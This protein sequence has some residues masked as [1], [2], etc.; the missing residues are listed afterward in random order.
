MSEIHLP[1]SWKDWRITEKTG[2]GSTE[3]V[4]KA[5]MEIYN[6]IKVIEVFPE[7]QKFGSVD[8]SDDTQIWQYYQ[9]IMTS[10]TTEIERTS[11]LNGITNILSIEDYC[12]EEVEKG[13]VIYIRME[14]LENLQ[15]Y[16]SRRNLTEEDAI[17][18]GIDICTALEACEKA[19]ILHGDIRQE[20]IFVSPSGY[21]KL[22]NFGIACKFKKAS[23]LYSSK[24]TPAYMSPEIFY[25]EEYSPA[26]DLYSLGIVLYRL[27]NRGRNPFVDA[28]K[29]M[30]YYK[31]R[32][33]AF[34]KRMSGEPILPPIDASPEFA[35]I[36]LKACRYS[37]RERYQNACEMRESLQMLLEE[38]KNSISENP[39]FP[40]DKRDRV[41]NL[42]AKILI[43]CSV[44][45]CAAGLFL[46][47]YNW[48][49][50]DK[51]VQ[52][53]T[54]YTEAENTV[55]TMLPEDSEEVNLD[56][57]V[58]VNYT[59]FD[60]YG[61][62]AIEMDWDSLIDECGDKIKLTK[63]AQ[64]LSDENSEEETF[65]ILKECIKCSLPAEC[66]KKQGSFSNG[67]KFSLEWS[68]TDEFSESFD[69]EF[70]TTVKKYKVKG[71]KKIEKIDGFENLS[72]SFVGIEP[73]GEAILD[74]EEAP[75]PESAYH[76]S[77]DTG[78]SNGDIITVLIDKQ[79]A[80]LYA[81]EN[82]K[83]PKT[84]TT[85][86][87]VEGLS[88]YATTVNDFSENAL[89]EMQ[90]MAE[91]DLESW[92]AAWLEEDTTITCCGNCFLTKDDDKFEMYNYLL[93]ENWI[94]F[95]F[96]IE[97][98][99]NDSPI[100]YYSYMGYGNMG[101]TPEGDVDWYNERYSYPGYDGISDHRVSFT[102]EN[103]ETCSY[104]GYEKPEEIVDLLSDTVGYIFENNV[105]EE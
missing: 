87:T 24:D 12:V 53:Q 59:G 52:P 8:S 42:C 96:K 56:K 45:V 69:T 21:Y 20:N 63:A 26:S 7:E 83:Y 34:E 84:L 27:M 22:G 104:Y 51:K 90:D 91:D 99:H 82:G 57:Y 68:I 62:V 67:D 19:H 25:G 10:L 55:Q 5:C 80:L 46:C 65:S 40:V 102:L 74:A 66:Y 85:Q 35:E 81:E 78:F 88:S 33:E 93:V 28:E 77:F 71:L 98:E 70:V 17:Q 39:M 50:T 3:T 61:S 13:W 101:I 23:D 48:E 16:A 43:V 30:I 49:K 94:Y 54:E 9:D 103:G 2:E 95:I 38:G 89:K 31:D 86:V 4:Y 18:V 79:S 11:K 73:E 58:R 15:K 105:S 41:K 100:T 97:L 32:E 29:Q 76:L 60:G 1:D 36:I 64:E 72:I 6:A 92:Q 14:Y 75:L 47:L 44:F 37:P